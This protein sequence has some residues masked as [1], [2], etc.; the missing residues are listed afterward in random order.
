MKAAIEARVKAEPGNAGAW[1]ELVMVGGSEFVP[2]EF[3]CSLFLTFYKTFKIKS[4]FIKLEIQ[5][6]RVMSHLDG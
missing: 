5:P 1:R 6:R 4:S 3:A 2:E